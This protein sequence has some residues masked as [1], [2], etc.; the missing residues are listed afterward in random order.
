MVPAPPGGKVVNGPENLGSARFEERADPLESFTDTR[1][2][3]RLY[4][5]LQLVRRAA[6]RRTGGVLHFLRVHG[7]IGHRQL[8]PIEANVVELM[9]GEAREH[10]QSSAILEFPPNPGQ[11]P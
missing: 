6:C 4:A 1:E 10:P 3:E 5:P 7:P 8:H 11:N 2:V 9:V